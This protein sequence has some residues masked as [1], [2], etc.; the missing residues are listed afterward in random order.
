MR[1]RN[2]VKMFQEGGV[3]LSKISFTM[4]HSDR[5]VYTIYGISSE[6]MLTNC[7]IG[8]T[9]VHQSKFYWNKGHGTLWNSVITKVT[10]GNS[11]RNRGAIHF[12]LTQA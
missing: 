12:Y 7:T 2:A 6:D 1:F 10:V 5:K 8:G 9:Q 11:I 3:E 4:R